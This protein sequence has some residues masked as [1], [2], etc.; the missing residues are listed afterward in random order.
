M[1]TRLCT[2]TL[3]TALSLLGARQAA[4]DPAPREKLALEGLHLLVR[5][6]T[7]P[8]RYVHFRVTF[9]RNG[10]ELV[11]CETMSRILACRKT[12]RVMVPAPAASTFARLFRNAT[13]R[14]MPCR[15]RLSM[16]DWQEA[17]LTWKTNSWRGKIPPREL[18]EV[19]RCIP[20][21]T[22]V[23]WLLAQWDA[24]PAP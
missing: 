20:Y 2:A 17:E 14:A 23:R 4:A 15:L 16:A 8:Q 13:E 19:A 1:T 9:V 10:L 11:G 12:R 22:L 18:P 5:R 24:P 21:T 6:A 3:A 7:P